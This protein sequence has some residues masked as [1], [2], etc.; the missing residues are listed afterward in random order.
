MK[1]INKRL[2]SVRLAGGTELDNMATANG[3]EEENE[4]VEWSTL[5]DYC[6][7]STVEIEE[8]QTT[9]V[10]R[11]YNLPRKL[12]RLNRFISRKLPCIHRRRSISSSSEGVAADESQQS[13]DLNN[14]KHFKSKIKSKNNRTIVPFNPILPSTTTH[15]VGKPEEDENAMKSKN[16]QIIN[17]NLRKKRF[18]I[19]I[20][21]FIKNSPQVPVF[22][23]SI[24]HQQQASFYDDGK[25]FEISRERSG[26]IDGR[27]KAELT[28]IEPFKKSCGQCVN[29]NDGE[30][31]D[32][33]NVVGLPSDLFCG[34]SD[35]LLDELH[36][37]NVSYGNNKSEMSELCEK[38]ERHGI[39]SLN[40][41]EQ[42]SGMAEKTEGISG[43]DEA[44]VTA[45]DSP[46]RTNEAGDNVNV[47]SSSTKPSSRLTM[48]LFRLAKY[49]WYWGPISRSEAEERLSDQPDGAFLVRDSSDDRYLLSLSF[50]SFDKTLH[51]RI[52]HSNGIFSFYI[53]PESES[54]SSVVELIEHSMSYSQSGVFC[55]S[56]A[57]TPGATSYPVRL[58][59]PVSRFTQVRSLQYLCRFVIRQYTRV[60]LIQQLP[61]PNRIKGYIKEAHY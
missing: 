11:L 41:V 12:N 61:L 53:Q 31:D 30:T 47:C 20:N 38:S 58:T 54:H 26:C 57:R 29:F 8:T 6:D 56:K 48:E 32:K 60:D 51:T 3:G 55:Y 46:C 10:N 1:R 2:N 27:G 9:N 19:H 33:Y 40:S 44:L 4:D 36:N 37:I 24:N 17:I 18:K 14:F 34:S 13:S 5:H 23:S 28:G 59:K 43:R 49:G 50:R 52:E 45:N 16:S 42:Y 25:I 21:S 7:P 35:T 22:K 15:L 39:S